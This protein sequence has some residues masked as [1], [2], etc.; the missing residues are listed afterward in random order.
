M[1][2]RN[3]TL[4]FQ[5]ETAPESTAEVRLAALTYLGRTDDPN[6]TWNVYGIRS[7]SDVA[8][9]GTLSVIGDGKIAGARMTRA[10]DSTTAWSDA[11]SFGGDY[12]DFS[13]NV[14]LIGTAAA[15]TPIHY[16]MW[17]GMYSFSGQLDRLQSTGSLGIYLSLRN[18]GSR[19]S[20]FEYNR[21][22][23]QAD[24]LYLRGGDLLSFRYWH[25]WAVRL[26]LNYQYSQSPLVNN[27]Q[28]ALGGLGS[29]RGYYASEA[30]GDT[31]ISESLELPTPTLK[32][33]WLSSELF[34]YYDAAQA[35]I[36][37][38]L[39]QQTSHFELASTGLGWHAF[40]VPAFD[41][42]FE[43]AHVLKNGPRTHRDA[44]RFRFQAKYS[45]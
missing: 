19:D 37:Q 45:Y 41:G 25:D 35:G 36:Q 3:E 39:S 13:Q 14:H 2:Q 31:G 1:F 8:A 38:P 10:L 5:S 24:F 12:K 4:A 26:N 28:F 32:L 43:W 29:V 20:D 22:G 9:V 30:L 6:W 21:A 44:N 42:A 11:L 33:P 34:A 15:I 18:I 17:S 16:L 27:E 23:A 7:N 40:H